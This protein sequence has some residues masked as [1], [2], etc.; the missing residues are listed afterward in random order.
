MTEKI[1]MTTQEDHLL[2]GLVW[3]IRLR[4]IAI[5][6]ILI[7]VLITAWILN[8]KLLVVQIYAIAFI[9]FIFNIIFLY[10]LNILKKASS[11]SIRALNFQAHFQI[12]IDLVCLTAL[13]HFTA[14]IENPF[15]FY[16]IFHVII[17]SILLE[18]REAFFQITFAVILFLGVSYGECFGL[19]KHHSLGL[20]SPFALYNNKIYVFGLSIVF[21]S[22]L[23]IS[24]YM[25]ASI[26][27]KLRKREQSL[28][29]AN[30][31][32]K[33]KETI[34]S[35]YVLKVTHDIKED[36]AAIYGCIEPV[37]TGIIGTLIEPQETMLKRAQRRSK[38]LI[39]YVNDLLVV[40]N[41]KLTKNLKS[42]K[43]SIPQ[44]V[45]D[46][47]DHILEHADKKN[48]SYEVEID[49]GID[50]IEGI[51]ESIK[52]ALI[53]LLMNAIK[54]TPDSGKI[55]LNVQQKNKSV[56]IKIKD[57]GV[58]I[59]KNS[60]PKIFDEFYRVENSKLNDAQG[61]GLGL[62]IVKQIAQMHGGNVHVE[63]EVD[64]GSTFYLEIPYNFKRQDI[65]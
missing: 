33:E 12:S 53:N 65:T 11:K 9:F 42:I 61:S 45:T 47:S 50:E 23:Y 14:G 51:P 40:T 17:A 30:R 8:I 64:V 34:K 36:L 58:G 4:W 59:P 26:S 3:L 1:N 44:I 52:Q 19:I 21:I 46:V 31:L 57:N 6:G 24:S 15:I 5:A 60:L 39:R 55:S 22:T 13:L 7:T 28:R 32:L 18:Q 2:D 37:I 38:F 41:M 35:R 48:I 16:Y 10:R 43:F 20:N 63:S 27:K 62:A 56:L 29:D 54:Y 25:A 49:S